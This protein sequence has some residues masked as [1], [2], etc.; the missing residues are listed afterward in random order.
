[1]PYAPMTTTGVQPVPA[2]KPFSFQPF[3]GLSVLIQDGSLTSSKVVPSSNSTDSLTSSPE[4]PGMVL[5]PSTAS[6]FFSITRCFATSTRCGRRQESGPGSFRPAGCPFTWSV[7]RL[8]Q[9]IVTRAFF[10]FFP[11]GKKSPFWKYHVPA[12]FPAPW[13]QIQLAPSRVGGFG[14][15]AAGNESSR[16]R[17]ARQETRLQGAP[18]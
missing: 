17:T 3:S 18:S 14:A 15:P 4:G 7:Q 2:T 9:V 11:A 6:A 5:V 16:T 10:G 13:C 1:M 12:C 8:S